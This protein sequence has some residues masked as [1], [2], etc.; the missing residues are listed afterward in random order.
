VGTVFIQVKSPCDTPGYL[1]HLPKI[2]P[3]LE[4]WEA[5]AIPL[6]YGRLLLFIYILVPSSQR[7][8]GHALQRRNSG[9]IDPGRTSTADLL[10]KIAT[11]VYSALLWW[12]ARDRKFEII[13]IASIGLNINTILKLQGIV[14]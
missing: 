13:E 6:N 5:T 3:G 4:A 8:V 2:E 9:R 11:P 12:V 10:H 1:N 14:Y 7:Q